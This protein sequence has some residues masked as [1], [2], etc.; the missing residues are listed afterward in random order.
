MLLWRTEP[1]VAPLRSS[2][3]SPPFGAGSR[4]P[5]PLHRRNMQGSNMQGCQ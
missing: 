3:A 1:P 5:G 4:A 2:D